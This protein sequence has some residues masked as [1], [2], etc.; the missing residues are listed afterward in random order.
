MTAT[1]IGRLRSAENSRRPSLWERPAPASA[2]D[3]Q[4]D[5]VRGIVEPC[6]RLGARMYAKS[7]WGDE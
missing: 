3:K 7:R 5:R 1:P 2:E 4:R 6:A